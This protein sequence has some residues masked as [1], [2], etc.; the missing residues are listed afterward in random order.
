MAK[1]HSTPASAEIRAATSV[2]IGRQISA[3]ESKRRVLTDELIAIQRARAQGQ[4]G[5]T[6][7]PEDARLARARA[8]EML[9]GTAPEGLKLDIASRTREATL[10]IDIDAC[11]IAID[12]LQS[13]STRI[14]AAE[15]A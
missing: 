7:L 8:L 4:P 14:R 5:E 9:N 1:Q 3:Y 10:Q 6:I 13:E 12:A 15:A 11:G 2:E